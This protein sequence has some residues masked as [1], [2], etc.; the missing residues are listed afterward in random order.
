MELF[1]GFS[2][3]KLDENKRTGSTT[4][5]ETVKRDLMNHLFTERGS[6]VMMPNYGTCLPTLT[7]EQGT[8]ELVEQVTKDV[9]EVFSYDPRVKMIG[10]LVVRWMPDRNAILVSAEL[11]YV[12]FAVQQPFDVIAKVGG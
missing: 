2:L 9:A 10:E 7:F 5:I 3:N 12:D 6:R 4:G 8:E 11:F 1:R